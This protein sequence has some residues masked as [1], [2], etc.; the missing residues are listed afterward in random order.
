MKCVKKGSILGF[1]PEWRCSPHAQAGSFV[2][3]SCICCYICLQL[4]AVAVSLTVW[5]WSMLLTDQIH[6]TSAISQHFK[7]DLIVFHKQSIPRYLKF[8]G[9]KLWYVKGN[10]ESYYIYCK[11]HF[12]SSQCTSRLK[13]EEGGIACPCSLMAVLYGHKTTAWWTLQPIYNSYN[14]ILLSFFI[15]SY[16]WPPG[17]PYWWGASPPG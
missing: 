1:C 13:G 6:R 12:Q 16:S 8:L 7:V 2:C 14:H 3:L 4:A 5:S 11:L 15:C 9:I 10:S 17:S